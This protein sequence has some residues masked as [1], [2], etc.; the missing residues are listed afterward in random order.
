MIMSALKTITISLVGLTG[1]THVIKDPL[2][3][4]SLLAIALVI[5]KEIKEVSQ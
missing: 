1:G 3:G 2:L 4:L 5:S